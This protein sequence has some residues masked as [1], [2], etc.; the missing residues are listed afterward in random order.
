MLP[1]KGIVSTTMLGSITSTLFQLALESKRRWAS[2]IHLSAN[3]LALKSSVTISSSI[4]CSVSEP[5]FSEEADCATGIIVA[6]CR[7]VERVENLFN[8]AE[9]AF[10]QERFNR[11][12]SERNKI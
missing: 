6:A 5:S 11:E 10:R 12:R 2:A 3:K 1:D 7:R 4:K 8:L 9:N